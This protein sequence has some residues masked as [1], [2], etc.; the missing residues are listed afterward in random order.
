MKV[1]HTLL[2]WVG[3]GLAITITI[4][5]SGN[6]RKAFILRLGKVNFLEMKYLRTFS[7]LDSENK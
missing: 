2:A 7:Q 1:K 6:L 3:L 5:V 4:G